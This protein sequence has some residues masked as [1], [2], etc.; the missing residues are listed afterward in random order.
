MKQHKIIAKVF[1]HNHVTPRVFEKVCRSK[2]GAIKESR[3]LNYMP[4]IRRFAVRWNASECK[5]EFVPR[6]ALG[7]DAWGNLRC[8]ASS[9]DCSVCIHVEDMDGNCVNVNSYGMCQDGREESLCET[10]EECN[11]DKVWPELE[12]RGFVEV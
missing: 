6:S 5:D 12:A 8:H 4:L 11:C 7:Y 9:S 3:E 1:D 2:S 10:R